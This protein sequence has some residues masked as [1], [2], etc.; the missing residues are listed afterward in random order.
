MAGS[1]IP[2]RSGRETQGLP[3]ASRFPSRHRPGRARSL[4]ALQI[5][6]GSVLDPSGHPEA[7]TW[8]GAVGAFASSGETPI[9]V[10]YW[11]LR[12]AVERAASAP[13]AGDDDRGCRRARSAAGRRRRSADVRG[14]TDGGLPFRRHRLIDG[15]GAD[16]GCRPVAG[17][18]VHDRL[19]RARLRRGRRCPRGRA[20][21][22]HRTHG[23]RRDPPGRSRRHPAATAAFD[24]P[25]ADSS[26]IPTL[27]VSRL[28]VDS[29]DRGAV[30]GRR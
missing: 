18:D 25:F 14:R 19:R 23:A 1:A 17:Q 21:P 6:P 10:A 28:A 12:D 22:R 26:Q 2:S 5:R 7:P 3:G 24:E 29:S 4:H 8:H 20:S 27:L 11:T 13:F 16:A 9:P 15:R 30:R